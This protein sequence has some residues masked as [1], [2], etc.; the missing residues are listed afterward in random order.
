MVYSGYDWGTTKIKEKNLVHILVYLVCIWKYPVST[1]MSTAYYLKY[2]CFIVKYYFKHVV[3]GK[4]KLGD[5][6]MI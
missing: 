5:G 3:L 6:A 2:P 1:G 4:K